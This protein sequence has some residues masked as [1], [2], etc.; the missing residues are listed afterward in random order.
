MYVYVRLHTFCNRSIF[1][2]CAL[3]TPWANNYGG[4]FPEKGWQCRS[5]VRTPLNPL[6]IIYTVN[7]QTLAAPP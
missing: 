4:A 2:L 1:L 3:G 6:C 5:L 7:P